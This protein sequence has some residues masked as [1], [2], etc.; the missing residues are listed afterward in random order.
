[1]KDILP[2][3]EHKKKLKKRKKEKKKK[4][5]NLRGKDNDSLGQSVRQ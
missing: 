5:D 2:Q 1:M 3:V 4:H